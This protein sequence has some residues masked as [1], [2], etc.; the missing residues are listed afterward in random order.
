MRKEKKVKVAELK[1]RNEKGSLKQ[2]IV[3]TEVYLRIE[4][5]LTRG[6]LTALKV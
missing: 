6:I 4:N 1:G 3:N 2:F 5:I